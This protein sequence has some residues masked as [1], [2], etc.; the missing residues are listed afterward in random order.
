M[1]NRADYTKERLKYRW[2]RFGGEEVP[3]R[4]VV[5][6]WILIFVAIAF[7]GFYLTVCLINRWQPVPVES[8]L[9][10]FRV[11]FICMFWISSI[12]VAWITIGGLRDLYRLFNGL[13]KKPFDVMDDG[14]VRKHVNSK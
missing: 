11:L 6:I 9:R 3:R 2:W 8:W 14:T 5:L 10:G 4:D 7:G 12:L 13:R 1:L